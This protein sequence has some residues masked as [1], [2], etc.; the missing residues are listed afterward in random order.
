M[1]STDF[2][3][4]WVYQHNGHE[5]EF[6]TAPES[7]TLADFGQSYERLQQLRPFPADRG[8]FI[9]LAVSVVVPMLPAILAVI[10]LVIILK[11]LLKALG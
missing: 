11:T 2:H 5:A 1:Q 10:P 4:K 7:S 3:E 9:A 6:L 8:A